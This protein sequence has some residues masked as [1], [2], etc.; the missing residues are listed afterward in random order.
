MVA[1]NITQ[2]QAAT[3]PAKLIRYANLVTGDL[4]T[5]LIMLAIFFVILL[6]LKK[7]DFDEALLPTS[8]AAFILSLILA[9]A[10]VLNPMFIFVFLLMMALTAF[11]MHMQ[12]P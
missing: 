7:F 3:N 11:Y 9:A 1:Y 2:L 8:F 6:G 12:K 5:G 4:L 10:K